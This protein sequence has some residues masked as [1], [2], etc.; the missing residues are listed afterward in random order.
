MPV[1]RKGEFRLYPSR[2]Q[3]EAI[4]GYCGACRYVYNRGLEERK[5]AYQETGKGLSFAKQCKAL[6]GWR[7]EEGTTWLAGYHTHALQGALKRLDLAFAAFFRRVKAGEKPGFPRYKSRHRISGFGF[8]QYGNGWL[9]DLKECAHGKVRITGIGWVTLRGKTRFHGTPKTCEV[10]ERAGNWYLSVTFAVEAL[11]QRKR[12][13]NERVG[14][15]WGVET[16]TT[17]AKEDGTFDKQPNPRYLKRASTRL[18][19]EQRALARKK[20]GSKRRQK[21]KRK[22]ARL[23]QKVANRRK[24][25]CHKLTSKQVAQYSHIAVEKLSP[26]KMSAREGASKKGLNRGILDAVAGMYHYLLRC[27]AEEA[28]SVYV[29]VDPRVHAPTQTCHISGRRE[30]KPQSQRWHT[31]PSGE[32]MGRDENAA[33]VILQISLGW[34]PPRRREDGGQ[35]PDDS[36]IRETPSRAA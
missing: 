9:L 31:L 15:D 28:G 1:Q 12:T 20:K 4:R 29:E 18:K 14:I 13:G 21:Q 8:K 23:H 16:F 19:T 11:P 22:V 35:S 27:K 24:D 26:K 32:R 25:F 34:E 7:K 5:K 17:A 6:T 30:Y 2:T 3:E 36:P 10:I 33:R